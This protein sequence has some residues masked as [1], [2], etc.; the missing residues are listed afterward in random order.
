[1]HIEHVVDQR[2]DPVE[3]GVAHPRRWL[4]DDAVSFEMAMVRVVHQTHS[5]VHQVV[6][7]A[8]ELAVE[9]VLSRFEHVA[10]NVNAPLLGQRN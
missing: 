3:N 2:M 4:A 10:Q 6:E 7:I 9:A 1:M 5:H 8:V